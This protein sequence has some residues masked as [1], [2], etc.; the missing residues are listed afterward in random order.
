MLSLLVMMP[1]LPAGSGGGDGGG[2]SG[3][4]DEDHVYI[5]RRWDTLAVNY[6]WY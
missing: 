2:D 5:V 6:I 4:D 3:G 1:L